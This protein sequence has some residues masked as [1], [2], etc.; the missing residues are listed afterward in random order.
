MG[1][2]PHKSRDI[3]R[4]GK[5]RRNEK[6]SPRP[7]AEA[8]EFEEWYGITELHA[9]PLDHSNTPL[10]HYSNTPLLR[11]SATPLLPLSPVILNSGSAGAR[12]RI[13]EN[14]DKVVH[15]VR[16]FGHFSPHQKHFKL[17]LRAV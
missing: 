6:S 17:L 12:Q 15:G 10:L 8:H 3:H 1:P 9:T 14:L 13:R 4:P 11:Y 2:G 16:G 7:F 5:Q